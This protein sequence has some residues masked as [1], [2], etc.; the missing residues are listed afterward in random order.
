MLAR[1]QYILT[2]IV[3]SILSINTTLA[4]GAKIETNS[5]RGITSNEPNTASGI[6]TKSI[7][8]EIGLQETKLSIAKS[9][10]D[11]KYVLDKQVQT[12]TE[13]KLEDERNE[14]YRLETEEID[15]QREERAKRE[16]EK[17]KAE[18][19]QRKATEEKH[20]DNEEKHKAKIEVK[21]ESKTVIRTK[22]DAS[23]IDIRTKSNWSASDFEKVVPDK[24][25]CIIPVV[26]RI[27]DE[28]GINA[29]YLMS[30]AANETGWGAKLAG[31]NNY[32]NWSNDGIKSFDFNSVEE[33]SDYSV[34]SYK[35]Y[36]NTS[37]YKDTVGNVDEITVET[38]NTRYAINLDGSVNWDWS[39]TVI[40]IME[41][42]SRQRLGN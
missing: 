31:R 33:F 24:L 16:L 35:K 32:F 1:R 40:S 21:E 4:Y 19:E 27:E 12:L 37:F 38:V 36:L 15:R 9:K 30:V 5:D 7:E 39:K 6:N 3:A 17:A 25:K 22:S 13:A 29:L 20:K 41:K 34:K 8:D 26:M 10:I 42:L 14:R 2:L 11:T 23:N 28:L 18:E